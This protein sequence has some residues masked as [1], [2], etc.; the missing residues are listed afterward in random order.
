MVDVTSII[1]FVIIGGLAGWLAAFLVR[2][3]G[4]G[5]L[6]DIGIGVVGAVIGGLLLGGTRGSLGTFVVAFIGALILLVIVKVIR[7]I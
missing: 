1:W 7:R 3:R 5:V 6:G 2:G 4:L